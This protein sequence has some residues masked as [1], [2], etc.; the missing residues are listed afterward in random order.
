LASLG[1]MLRNRPLAA[2]LSI[3]AAAI[4]PLLLTSPPAPAQGLQSKLEAK[5]SRLDEVR[6]RKGVLT[7]TISRFKDEIEQLT[8]EVA[9]IRT[10]EAATRARLD[11][12]QAELDAAVAEL[13]AAK[14]KLAEARAHL[15]R[16]LL[17]LR[18]RLVAIY[19][20]GDSDLLSALVSSEGVDDFAAQAEY[21]D[22]IRGMDEAVVSRVRSLRDE[23]R[24]IVDRRRRAKDTIESAR[25]TIAAEERSLAAARGALQGRQQELLDTR[26]QRLAALARIGESEEE[27][28][29]SVGAIQA[30]IAA[31]LGETGALP[32]P[33]GPIQEGSGGLIWPVDGPIASG[34]GPRTINGTYEYHPGIDIAVPEGTPIRAA[35]AGTVVFTEPEASSGGYGNYTC[36]D[37]GGG[38]STCYAH[39][40][41]FAVS[42]GQSVSQGAIIGY[43]GCTGY[44]L[45]PH[46]HFEV[47]I[48]GAVTDPMGYL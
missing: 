19:E 48:N 9:G 37:H 47:R 11:A 40:S 26:G 32:L 39:Q 41:S 31:Q 12:K 2:T 25:D 10:R 27:L 35:A 6:E 18:E 43:T 46:L 4:F 42:A 1:P 29:G 28:D 21:L 30:Q 38:L 23:V 45:G 5:Q 44:C 36:I 16:A 14:G 33:A 3:L 17:A 8:D 13:D 15:G 34:F 24:S 22:R 7:S 20:N